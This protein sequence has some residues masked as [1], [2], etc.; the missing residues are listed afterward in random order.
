MANTGP[1]DNQPERAAEI[2]AREAPVEAARFP[3]P[4]ERGYDPTAR[5]RAALSSLAQERITNA[6]ARSG[7]NRLSG[8]PRP[9]PDRRPLLIAGAVALVVALGLGYFAY[10]SHSDASGRAPA[11]S[12]F[13]Y[14]DK[15]IPWASV[16]LDGAALKVAPVGTAAPLAIALGKH[17]I[18]WQA[19]AFQPQGCVFSVPA[20]TGDTCPIEAAENAGLRD[21]ANAHLLLLRASLA[22]L[23]AAQQR[24]LSQTLASVGGYTTAL[25]AG[26]SYPTGPDSEAV[27]LQQAS[28]T[29]NVH[30]ALNAEGVADIGCQTTLRALMINTCALNGRN[31][32]Q[33]CTAPWQMR[34]AAGVSSRWI[35]F[36]VGRLAWTVR[37]ADG[38]ALAQ[39]QPVGFG[40]A[41]AAGHLA[42]Y[43]IA[44]ESQTWR[45]NPL[46][47][48]DLYAAINGD[49]DDA[50]AADPA[51]VAA[52][53]AILGPGEQGEK[54]L[55]L[56]FVSGSSP[57][58]GCLVTISALD[59]QGA[60]VAGQ[61][62]ARY[63]YRLQQILA[64]NDIAH[65][66]NPHV[67]VASGAQ[68]TVVDQLAEASGQAITVG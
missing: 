33:L 27:T 45:V 14:L 15:D 29:L 61:S 43:A 52:Y 59:D 25:Q 1:V 2:R 10:S 60:P 23:S 31:C 34:Q 17:Q 62:G 30:L 63:L 22:S 20:A 9:Q 11:G 41:R 24:A 4:A 6:P 46:V 36:A 38:K 16:T 18:R 65:Q 7:T 66:L 44:W 21:V 32:M 8:A 67:P 28:A 39:N 5:Q 48:A 13:Y 42:P 57:A 53:E 35:A 50:I 40:N 26:E 55:R 64:A 68:K 58:A 37:A 51:C 19:E 47:G 49:R 54:K 3:A 56:Q 12:Q